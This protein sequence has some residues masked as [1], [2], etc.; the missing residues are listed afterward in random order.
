[1]GHSLPAHAYTA[2]ADELAA[3]AGLDADA[4]RV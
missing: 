4:G 3:Q 1:M 2:L